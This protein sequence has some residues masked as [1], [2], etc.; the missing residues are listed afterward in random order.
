MTSM[1]SRFY[2]ITYSIMTFETQINIEELTPL[3]AEKQEIFQVSID[4]R[5][6][7]DS[8][9]LLCNDIEWDKNWNNEDVKNILDQYL[10]A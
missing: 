9:C 7:L 2:S 4:L 5:D 10:I 1:L 3:E 8:E 6:Q